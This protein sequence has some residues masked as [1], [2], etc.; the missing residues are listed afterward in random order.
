MKQIG[1]L[2]NI[3][4]LVHWSV[5]V[6]PGFALWHSFSMHGENAFCLECLGFSNLLFILLLVSVLIHE[7]GHALAGRYLGIETER[8]VINGLGGAAYLRHLGEKPHET[9][10]IAIAGPLTN[11]ALGL[12]VYF[13][14]EAVHGFGNF[15]GAE[16]G[17]FGLPFGQRLLYF[18]F[19]YNLILIAFN[20]L[21][22]LPLDGGWVLDGLLRYI[23]PSEW[24][25]ITTARL[26][27][28]LAAGLFL[29]GAYI[30]DWIFPLIA[31]FIFW[32]ST[33][34][35]VRAKLHRRLNRHKIA[36]LMHQD[37]QRIE[38]A[39]SVTAAVERAAQ[40]PGSYFIIPDEQGKLDVM[41][42]GSQI[43]QVYQEN[44]EEP[45]FLKAVSSLQSYAIHEDTSLSVAWD[46][47]HHHQVPAFA[48]LR[49]D[50]VVGILEAEA[51]RQLVPLKKGPSI[52][53]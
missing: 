15:H 22:G 29:F 33:R 41:A 2:F 27:Q 6:F 13:Y 35:L 28:L 40:A 30:I 25:T 36:E 19:Y 12:L 52:F 17:I 31:A 37:F 46:Y 44:Q 18:F 43:V 48:V 10:L 49:G 14:L 3:P 34:L 1:K 47:V 4:V 50:E 11:I 9:V 7:L 26:G 8:I 39:E 21:P 5:I 42:A 51:I 20:L 24:A 38:A 23:M 45:A 53:H 32:Q 16:D